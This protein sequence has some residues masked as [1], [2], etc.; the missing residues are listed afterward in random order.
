MFTLASIW[1]SDFHFVAYL[2]TEEQEQVM[3][4]KCVAGPRGCLGLNWEKQVQVQPWQDGVAL[5]A[6]SS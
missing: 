2:E 4:L 1:H 6:W 3:I 5:N